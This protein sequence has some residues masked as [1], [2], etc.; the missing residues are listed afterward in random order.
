MEN[1]H[2]DESD[3]DFSDDDSEA[4]EDKPMTIEDEVEVIGGILNEVIN[5]R[6]AEEGIDAIE[7][8]IETEDLS[9]IDDLLTRDNYSEILEDFKEKVFF[10]FTL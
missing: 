1:Y 3:E 6:Q 10:R 2:I 4:G 7:E 9:S 5:E 8:G